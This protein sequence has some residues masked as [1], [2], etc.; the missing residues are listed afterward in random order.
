MR[1]A[2][3]HPWVY[4]TSGIERIFVEVLA[5]SRHEWTIYTHHHEPDSTYPALREAN[6][7]EL[8]PAVSVVRELV[9]LA[10]A[11]ATIAATRLPDDGSRVLLVSS[12]G[13]G[14]LVLTRNRIP[15]VCY[16]HTPLKIVHDQATRA[17]V[18]DL[19]RTKAMLTSLIGPAF[20]TVDRRLWRRYRHV[21]ANSGETAK[22]IE[23]ADLAPPGSVEVLRPG[24]DLARFGGAEEGARTRT[25]L[26]AGR[27][28]WQKQIELA[29]DALRLARRDGLDADL[30]I[31]GA[32]DVKSR[33]YIATLRE[34]AAD[35]PVRFEVDPTDEQLVELYRRSLALVFT[36]R[37][38]DFGMVPL[39]AMAAG[40]PVLAV[41]V[42]GPTESVLHDRTGWLLRGEPDAFAAAMAGVA[43]MSDGELDAMRDAC[44]A[45]AAEFSWDTF[46]ERLD[47]VLDA[48]ADRRPVTPP[49]R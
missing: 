26:V 40:L 22:R 41:G 7:V 39:E 21:L 4:L 20:T 16:C 13:L 23:S 6:V 35:L 30:V 34:R 12:E 47:D 32:V 49:G 48:V 42:G 10:K 38:E 15:A 46:T 1:V 5:R 44:R 19:G 3:Y 36:P 11:A 45:R 25:F 24:V 2:L 33:P 43:A 17:A 28:M 31:A 27:I 37:N 8:Q 29:I 18:A 14:D 9:P